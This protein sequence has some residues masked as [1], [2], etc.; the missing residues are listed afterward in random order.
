MSLMSYHVDIAL[1]IDTTSSMS[2][3]IDMVKSNALNFC[4]DLSETMT[5]QQKQISSLRV[6]AISF[7]DF[8]GDGASSFEASPFFTLPQQS[9]QLSSFVNTFHASGGYSSSYPYGFDSSKA[10]PPES[11]LEAIAGAITQLPWGRAEGARRQII[12]LWTDAYAHPLDACQNTPSWAPNNLQELT[13]LWGQ[14]MLASAKRL[15]LFAPDVYPWTELSE[16]WDMVLHYPSTAG[17]GLV[18]SDYNVI[19]QTIANSI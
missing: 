14:N 8:F 19:I 10:N 4:A 17:R 12:V 3:V 5:R 13:S 6:S 9:D 7:K 16:E 11:G 18:E 2:S 15:I 1:V